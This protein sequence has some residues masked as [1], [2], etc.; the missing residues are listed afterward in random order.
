MKRQVVLSILISLT[1]GL[2]VSLLHSTISDAIA[3]LAHIVFFGLLIA[4]LIEQRRND[5]EDRR[6]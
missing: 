2:V 6:R 4:A 3:V 5:R 1:F